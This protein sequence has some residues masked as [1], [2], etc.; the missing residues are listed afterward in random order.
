METTRENLYSI[1]FVSNVTGINPHTIRAWE[2]RYGAT[3]PVRDKN[4]RRLYTDN[5][6]HRLDLLNKLVSYGNNISDIAYMEIEELDRVFERYGGNQKNESK[7]DNSIDIE[8]TLSSIYL[9]IKFFK[10]DVMN[11]EMSKAAEALSSIDFA[12]KIV[13]PLIE[14]I[15]KLK[16]DG[17]MTPD[18]R[19]QIYLI[20]KSQL[21]KKIYLFKNTSNQKKKILICSPQGRL[22]ELGSMVATI[23]FLDLNY[24]VEYLGGNVK[25]EILGE[26]SK[27]FKADY[28]FVGLNYSHE[29]TMSLSE[30]QRYLEVLGESFYEKTKV[31][32]GAHDYCFSLPHENMECFSSFDAMVSSLEGAHLATV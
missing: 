32:I 13:K 17:L 21:I 22:N 31:L 30:K 19:E 4:G 28:I 26:L 15:R 16:G 1:Q 5:E 12:M 9:G 7:F 24:E 11:H 8:S 3:K 27:Q 23:L 6:I 29:S 10:L 18:Q 25:P 14:E 2:K 20:I